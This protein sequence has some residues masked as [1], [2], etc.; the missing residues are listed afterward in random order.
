MAEVQPDPTLNAHVAPRGEP[1]V[2]VA[3][4]DVPS[5][6]QAQATEPSDDTPTVISRMAARTPRPE[7]K[8]LGKLQG[9]HLAHFELCDAIGVGGMAAVIRARDTQLDR[10]VALKI[11]PPDIA[12][13]PENVLRFH[14]EARAAAKLNHENVASVFYYGEDQGLHFIAFEYVEGENVRSI[15]ER[16]GRLPV[17]E[18]VRY[19]LQIANGLAHSSARGVVHRDVKPSNIIITAT[20]QAKLVD[21]GLARQQDLH[22]EE[23]LTHSGVT[24]GTFDYISPEQAIEP[25]EVDVRSDIYSLGC[26]F[27]HMLTGRPPVPE[28]TAA[29]KLHHHQ[30]ILPID[31]R[32]HTAEIPDEVAAVLA[33]MM[34]KNPNERYQNA[35]D[36]VVHLTHL[37]RRFGGGSDLPEADTP[38]APLWPA[39][40]R[41]RPGVVAGVAAVVLFGVISIH[42]WSAAGPPARML[43]T[44][45]ART[46]SAEDSMAATAAPPTSPATEQPVAAKS[47]PT[48]LPGPDWKVG[49]TMAALLGVFREWGRTYSKPSLPVEAPK[50]AAQP[51]VVD[52]T[53][54]GTGGDTYETL[55]MAVAAARPGDVILIK[56]KELRVEPLSLSK[57]SMADLTLKPYPGFH[58]RL[59][60]GDTT[61]RDVAMFRLHDGRLYLEGL[62][63]HLRPERDEFTM[64]AVVELVG[65]G[66][67]S[68]KECIIT[69][70]EAREKPLALAKLADSTR[71]MKTEPHAVSMQTPS[72]HLEDCVVR[73]KGDLIAVRTARA[74]E[75]RIDNSLI[76]LAGTMLN[77]EA[78]ARDVPTLPLIQ[79]RLSHLTTYLF[80]HLVRMRALTPGKEPVAIHVN[81]ATNCVFASADGKP[82]V[83]LEGVEV[84]NEQMKS[85]LKWDGGRQNAYS[86]FQP[87]L[88]Q[89]PHG[90]EMPPLPMDQQRWRGFTGE[91]DALFPSL[92]F[93]D[94]ADSPLQSMLSR[95]SP[96]HFKVKADVNMQGYG[97][98]IERLPRPAP[99]GDLG[100]SAIS[101]P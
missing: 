20:G 46:K 75:L 101:G 61:E 96:S 77:I 28:G 66:Q 59:V 6:P 65:D 38:I 34:A 68:F 55:P 63:F 43:P 84:S 21:M 23:A 91:A 88:D 10:D 51:I 30:H 100:A 35:E 40:P 7:E 99:L 39:R 53:V 50:L 94:V 81:P 71:V 72:L 89:V 24:L 1:G 57:K 9:R 29:K 56:A 41:F 16:R 69:L 83:H 93:A 78:A 3:S 8:F 47:A 25:R 37:T 31:P 42:E 52:P 92:R 87:M 17:G 44:P 13:D 97:A 60:L 86:R 4:P 2:P 27:Y 74:L 36:L 11:L 64:Q 33:R 58:P 90:D 18:A 26:T 62:E 73:G 85:I 32:Q 95:V 54:K 67:C 15:I 48:I 70:D 19:V 14:Q 49:E 79:L 45:A 82:L 12:A 5:E 76:A 22:A 80:D 98:D